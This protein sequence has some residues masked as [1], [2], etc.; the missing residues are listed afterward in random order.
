MSAPLLNTSHQIGSGNP[1]IVIG[2]NRS[3][4]RWSYQ[5]AFSR[6]RGLINSSE[7]ETL[8]NTKVAIPG[9]GGVGGLHLV[10][11]AR[12][13]IGRFVIADPDS[14]ECGNTN[15]QYGSTINSIGRQK[16][17]VMAEVATSINPE[18]EITKINGKIDS[19]N[20]DDFL[21]G[22]D[23]LV[24]GID[25][26]AIDARRHVFQRAAANN[27][28]AVTAG[29]MGFSTCWLT[30]DPNGM[31]FDQYFDIHDNMSYGRKVISFLI[32][33]CPNMLPLKYMDRR[34]A[35]PQE[36]RAPSVSSGCQLAT[37]VM[38]AEVIKLLLKRGPVKAA[39]YFK[40]FDAYLGKYAC[41]KL[42][43]GNRGPIQQIKRTW[44]ENDWKK[45]FKSID[46]QNIEEN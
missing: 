21:A 35:N 34:E 14:F 13:G 28:H 20:A 29:P 11:L 1:A 15:R 17:D 33:L 19:S 22:C 8:R 37:G 26:Y 2:G 25:L 30:F 36:K 3:A 44:L 46:F 32:G 38:A 43:F 10:T 7:Q 45:R 24:D 5:D 27:I 31:T 18:I 23:I 12:L 16:V 4:Q 6:N 40:I 42:R 39:P 9:M 41:K